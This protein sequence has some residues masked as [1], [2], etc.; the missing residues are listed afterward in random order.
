MKDI[1]CR[2][3]GDTWLAVL[4]EV[5]NSSHTVGDDSRE[6][7][8]ICASFTDADY[9]T[10]PVLVRFA[11][12]ENIVQMRKVFFTTEANEFGHSYLNRIRGPQ[13]RSD[14]SDV[15]DLLRREPLS[16]RA[17][18]VLAG[19]GNGNVPCINVVHFL[20]REQGLVATYF[21]R[22]QDIFRKF[23]ADAVCI[24]DMACRVADAAGVPIDR[25]TGIISSAHIYL[26][27]LSEV[28]RMLAEAES[29][30][31]AASTGVFPSEGFRGVTK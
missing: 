12:R 8:H 24:F 1:C 22:G 28:G 9:D 30:P 18:I 14:L 11:S 13:G 6:L 31:S 4:R 17:A 3:L 10:D 26:A 15:I 25:V 21:A 5:Y 19:E 7:L 16:K 23:Y 29:M 20:C 2:S 27:D